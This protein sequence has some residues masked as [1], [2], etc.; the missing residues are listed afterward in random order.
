MVLLKRKHTGKDKNGC[1]RLGHKKVSHKKL[2]GSQHPEHPRENIV[3]STTQ[4]PVHTRENPEMSSMLPILHS[5]SNRELSTGQSSMQQCSEGK[6]F[7]MIR[8]FS[9]HLTH[10]SCYDYFHKQSL[11]LVRRR[12]VVRNQRGSKILHQE[13]S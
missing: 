9:V 12:M 6:D 10:S 3:L 5:S 4:S 2:G 13:R 1:N 7:T 11:Q 8:K